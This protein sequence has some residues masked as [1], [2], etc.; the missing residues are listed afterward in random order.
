MKY[1][2]FVDESGQ[3]AS[4]RDKSIVGGFVTTWDVAQIIQ[5]ID[6]AITVV[7][8]QHGHRFSA[9][10]IHMA[11]L[12]FPEKAFQETD[13]TRYSAIPALAREAFAKELL[14]ALK[15]MAVCVFMSVNDG[16]SFGT[17]NEQSRYGNNLMA[18][19]RAVF[20]HLGSPTGND[21]LIAI[22][23]RAKT[24]LRDG[25]G[26][27]AY[28]AQL[29]SHVR[30]VFGVPVKFSRQYLPGFD[31]ADVA[32][33]YLRR[34][35]NEDSTVF[36]DTPV[37]MTFAKDIGAQDPGVSI[38]AMASSLAE[39]G[40]LCSAYSLATDEK[41][42]AD[43][44]G[45]LDALQ[46]T[47]LLEQLSHFLQLGAEK[48]DRRTV[49]H[50]SLRESY[51]IMKTVCRLAWREFQS[52]QQSRG[53]LDLCLSGLNYATTCTNHLGVA[54]AQADFIERYEQL[55]RE[56]GHLLPSKLETNE[57]SL[58]FRNRAYNN[59]FND[60]R[61][62]RII[63][64]FRETVDARVA[65]MGDDKDDLTGEMCGTIGQAY[66]FLAR[67]ESELGSFAEAY[68][69][70]SLKYFLPTHKYHAMSVNFL[71]TLHWQSGDIQGALA[72]F[73]RHTFLGDATVPPMPSPD[74]LLSTA[75]SWLDKIRT[76][77]HDQSG[78]PFD[79]VCLLRIIAE[80]QALAPISMAAL[81]DLGEWV[82]TYPSQQHPHE[83]IAK[84]LGVLYLKHDPTKAV[85]WFDRA[86]A[87]SDKLGF[88]VQT[89]AL[90]PFGLRAVAHSLSG[91]QAAAAADSEQLI[92][93]TCNLAKRSATFGNYLDELG[94]NESLVA[95]IKAQDV[96][97][98]CRWLPFAYA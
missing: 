79:V 25:E 78:T 65:Q 94:G 10:D 87:I 34:G 13:R 11:P 48:T 38:A 88:T 73:V 43:I 40:D 31:M 92:S 56:H 60:Y 2:A 30:S 68:L 19:L 6:Q 29:A 76:E 49:E 17:E 44:L 7:S 72:T 21:L 69:E 67:T 16:F 46:G 64:I 93:R 90:S 89:I 15:E 91:D 55:L 61:F 36:G 96:A 53:A 81:N 37:V 33:H 52:D 23:P 32:C 42:R 85:K 98:I 5:R 59:E 4:D 18:A 14:L 74:S 27:E 12:L 58:S 70:R 84:W 95:D 83:L 82:K 77:R 57:R 3:F 1:Y 20:R 41:Q 8:H 97:A 63:D 54:G 39:N 45:R 62:S 22:A 75:V 9:N 26:K 28:H 71:A 35:V 24:C 51:E 66:A 50:S 47:A 86:I 80:M